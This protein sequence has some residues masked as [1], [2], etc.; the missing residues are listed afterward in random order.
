MVFDIFEGKM[1]A[2]T[3]GMKIKPAAQLIDATKQ[4][5]RA[6]A[7]ICLLCYKHWM[8]RPGHYHTCPKRDKEMSK[9]QLKQLEADNKNAFNHAVSR[10]RGSL[11]VSREEIEEQQTY[12]S[13]EVID[14]LESMGHCII[15]SRAEGV[16]SRTT[17]YNEALKTDETTEPKRAKKPTE[18]EQPTE[19]KRP[20]TSKKPDPVRKAQKEPSK[21]TTTTTTQQAEA[22]DREVDDLEKYLTDNVMDSE[23]NNDFE[24][25]DVPLKAKA[26]TEAEKR[27][28]EGDEKDDVPLKAKASTEA[29]KLQDEE[30][31]HSPIKPPQG[32]RK[33]ALI[34]SDDDRE[35]ESDVDVIAPSPQKK[36]KQQPQGSKKGKAPARRQVLPKSSKKAPTEDSD[37]DEDTNATDDDYLSDPDEESQEKPDEL[38]TEEGYM[39]QYNRKSGNKAKLLDIGWYKVPMNFA[40]DPVFLEFENVYV[41]QGKNSHVRKNLL[42]NMKRLLYR[43]SGGNSETYSVDILDDMKFDDVIREL[44]E[45]GISYNTLQDYYKSFAH[46]I[47]FQKNKYGK[48]GT[49]EGRQMY[50]RLKFLQADVEHTGTRVS[51]RGDEQRRQAKV[52]KA[53]PPTPWEVT[54]VLRSQA[55]DDVA[56]LLNDAKEGV[57]LNRDQTAKVN[58][59]L[60]CIITLG[61]ANRPSAC[62]GLTVELV[63]QGL[64]QNIWKDPKTGEEAVCIKSDD[65]KTAERYT[66][67]IILKGYTLE[68]FKKYAH[69]VRPQIVKKRG[70][71]SKGFLLQKDG[72]AFD[73][74][75]E[76]PTKLQAQ[77]N[78]PAINNNDA[79]DSYETYVQ[80]CDERET[81]RMADILWQTPAVRDK[82]YKV[83]AMEI[84]NEVYDLQVRMQQYYRTHNKDDPCPKEYP[85]VTEPSEE[86]EPLPARK[87]HKTQ[88]KQ[89]PGPSHRDQDE[90]QPGPSHQ[91]DTSPIGSPT[92][93]KPARQPKTPRKPKTL[94]KSPLKGSHK[95]PMSIEQ[96]ARSIAD[97]IQEHTGDFVH[98]YVEK[99][100]KNFETHDANERGQLARK[101]RQ[102]R[103]TEREKFLANH[104]LKRE[105]KLRKKKICEL[106]LEDLSDVT[107][108]TV[109]SYAKSKGDNS[110][111]AWGNVKPKRVRANMESIIN[112]QKADQP[113]TDQD[114]YNLSET[115]AWPNLFIKDTRTE[116]G[117]GV[118]T[119]IHGI[120][121]HSIVCDYH[122]DIIRKKEGER[123]LKEY[124]MP[125]CNYL[126]FF[127][128][129]NGSDCVDACY[130]C[131]CHPKELFPKLLGRKINHSTAMANL[132]PQLRGVEFVDET[133]KK[134][135]IP[136]VVLIANKDIPPDTEVFFDYGVRKDEDGNR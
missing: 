30:D 34:T 48:M 117:E 58:R 43:M 35:D 98:S 80:N 7:V 76:A 33:R 39:K 6:P 32:S 29:E 83:S 11:F 2:S 82:N 22:S 25:D 100:I 10:M 84:A 104:L 37:D 3:S 27:Q 88:D 103:D 4:S 65:H 112:I 111:G 18:G 49:E 47:K 127:S 126:L 99:H 90:E 69:Y 52:M 55:K 115:Q 89:Q 86:N 38:E 85:E 119:G 12:T 136:M 134:S 91:A 95:R 13:D 96:K 59:F 70:A 16:Y 53:K 121:K 107:S 129:D 118:F 15:P 46:F 40:N 106:K 51:S 26:S 74:A 113:L 31:E 94:S 114:I 71:T 62:E 132:K 101:V 42:D 41:K 93:R 28:D 81:K 125:D 17:V 128:H 78:L 102:I 21:A 110:G 44:E 57:H 19:A 105:A 8:S 54:A 9:E 14:L 20:A 60:A 64:T 108:E 92:R 123:R 24:V 63:E 131:K 75:S 73:K 45:L 133:G 79:R 67:Q 77:Y 72:K 109:D 1:A 124:P 116:R 5:H 23:W 68:F 66:V 87:E 135:K 61:Q 56:K 50:R 97:W 130:P 122:G 36:V 120:K